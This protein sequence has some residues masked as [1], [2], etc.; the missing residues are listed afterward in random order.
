MPFFRDRRPPLRVSIERH[1]PIGD[2]ICFLFFMFVILPSGLCFL[3]PFRYDTAL[4][5]KSPRSHVERCVYLGFGMLSLVENKNTS[6]AS[7]AAPTVEKTC[8]KAIEEY[9]SNPESHFVLAM[10]MWLHDQDTEHIQYLEKSH[11]LAVQQ[12]NTEAAKLAAKF[13]QI[14]QEAFAEKETKN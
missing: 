8:A 4:A 12:N 2:F 5:P 6:V 11:D 13:L 9:P 7:I 1:D 3:N 10:A 14:R